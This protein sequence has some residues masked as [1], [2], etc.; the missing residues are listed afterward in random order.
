[1]SVDILWRGF[2][3]P[4]DKKIDVELDEYYSQI[5][6]Q[7]KSSIR[8]NTLPVQSSLPFRVTDSQYTIRSGGR[9]LSYCGTTGSRNQKDMTIEEQVFMQFINNVKDKSKPFTLSKVSANSSSSVCMVL[10]YWS[11]KDHIWIDNVG[12]V[13]KSTIAPYPNINCK[14]HTDQEIG[15]LD[16]KEWTNSLVPTFHS[17][18]NFISTP[19]TPRKTVY[20]KSQD[21]PIKGYKT[22]M[23]TSVMSP[24][25]QPYM[26]VFYVNDKSFIFQQQDVLSLGFLDYPIAIS[27][28]D[29]MLRL[30]DI[31]DNNH[32]TPLFFPQPI[33]LA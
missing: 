3:K 33:I 13:H 24:K 21:N 14:S 8:W 1:M 9:S 20:W 11:G 2:G 18:V 6:K 31:V 17:F 15:V 5:W 19:S 7:F 23:G 26:I 30:K 25:R 16:S 29:L 12:I 32:I 4:S 27:L 10:E 28:C 22:L